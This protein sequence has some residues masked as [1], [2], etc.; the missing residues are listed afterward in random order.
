[1]IRTFYC[2]ST[3]APHLLQHIGFQSAE[4]ADI[5]HSELAS[6]TNN[7]SNSLKRRTSSGES[8]DTDPEEATSGAKRTKVSSSGLQNAAAPPSSAPPPSSAVA[9][10]ANRAR[11]QQRVYPQPW[12]KQRQP[13]RPEHHQQPC[14]EEWKNINVVR[15][16]RRNRTLCTRCSIMDFPPLPLKRWSTASGAWLT[17]RKGRWPF[18]TSDSRRS[19]INNWEAIMPGCRPNSS[20]WWGKPL[21]WGWGTAASNCRRRRLQRQLEV[22]ADSR[23]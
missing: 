3:V 10:A 20:T 19:N 14:D 6:T 9:A 15:R 11:Q 1:M 12:T 23:T 16:L 21:P 18:G 7:S 17:R 5:F 8:V 2:T 13:S 22:A 4:P